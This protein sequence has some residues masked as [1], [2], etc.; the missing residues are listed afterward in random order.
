MI[1][2]LNMSIDCIEGNNHHDHYEIIENIQNMM[3]SME[4]QSIEYHFSHLN[5]DSGFDVKFLSNRWK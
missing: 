4:K 5:A 3:V 2:G 1:F